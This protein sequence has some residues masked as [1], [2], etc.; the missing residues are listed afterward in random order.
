MLTP[1][2]QKLGKPCDQCGKRI[3]NPTRATRKCKKCVKENYDKA[4]KNK[5]GKRKPQLNNIYYI[6]TH[7]LN[8]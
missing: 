7:K 8:K 4:M 6:I 3:V 2:G 1:K 5:F